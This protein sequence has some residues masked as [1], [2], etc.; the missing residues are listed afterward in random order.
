M[1]NQKLAS[2]NPLAA[3]LSGYISSE[4]NRLSALVSRFLD[5]ARPL[6]AETRPTEV[7]EVLD[8]A[9]RPVEDQWRGGKGAAARADQKGLPLAPPGAPR[10]EHEFFHVGPDAVWAH[11]DQV[12]D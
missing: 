3:E 11:G 7:T 5:F 1:L 12:G 8:K 9:L 10:G 2:A 6:Q 4:V